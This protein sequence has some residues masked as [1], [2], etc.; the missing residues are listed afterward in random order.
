MNVAQPS[1]RHINCSLQ[2]W[3]DAELQS[4]TNS[5]TSGKPNS[6]DS[7]EQRCA[8]SPTTTSSSMEVPNPSSTSSPLSHKESLLKVAEGGTKSYAMEDLLR[9][10]AASVAEAIRQQNRE[11][12]TPIQ[13]MVL[14]ETTDSGRKKRPNEEFLDELSRTAADALTRAL[15]K[16]AKLAE[17]GLEDELKGLVREALETSLNHI[18]GSRSSLDFD[19]DE[20]QR[21]QQQTKQGPEQMA[22]ESFEEGV[23]KQPQKTP[24]PLKFSPYVPSPTEIMEAFSTNVPE[25]FSQSFSTYYEAL[26]RMFQSQGTTPPCA[27][28][29]PFRPHKFSEQ[30]SPSKADSSKMEVC[31]MDFQ[32]VT[33]NPLPM[34]E[35]LNQTEALALVVNRNRGSS[36]SPAYDHQQE[37]FQPYDSP[38][39]ACIPRKKRTK[40]TDTRLVPPK[41]APQLPLPSMEGGSPFLLS[42]LSRSKIGGTLSHMA[43]PPPLPANIDPALMNDILKTL[44]MAN[45]HNH[46]SC[47]ISSTRGSLS[48]PCSRLPQMDLMGN[49]LP[50][51]PPPQPPP[52]PP[53][54]P[55]HHHHHHHP[56]EFC[57][58]IPNTTSVMESNPIRRSRSIGGKR[59]TNT[60]ST[61]NYGCD[62]RAFL[63]SGSTSDEAAPSLHPGP[64]SGI[65]P[66]TSTLTPIHLRKAK[67]MFFYTR[68]PNSNTLKAYF[69]D[70]KFQK[71][72]TAQL[73]KWFSNFREFYYIQMEKYARVAIT[74]GVRNPNDLTVTTNSELYRTL[75]LHYNRN[76]QIEIPEYFRVVVET[77]IREFFV[78]LKAGKDAEQSW[79][80]PIYKIIARMDQTVPE[81]FKDPTWMAQLA[82]G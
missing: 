10:D 27:F 22:E 21:Q 77:T 57:Y 64:L 12:T 79:K 29:T 25:G 68:Y 7:E 49:L 65:I 9:S 5:G 4:N 48:I 80:K 61:S 23:V 26:C 46:P 54:P 19:T 34:P 18:S 17:K 51:P 1:N 15:S 66:S 53:P 62:G 35:Q 74:E 55:H 43:S 70:V 32:K 47:S 78:A 75:A 36:G 67:L 52:P 8:S 2:K 81:Y 3:L 71:N 13:K 14:E 60:S 16:K 41:L 72:N 38:M 59:V 76:N 40:V 37:N 30:N 24:G 63:S 33:S 31:S 28:P 42:E 6:E 73:V 39:T 11:Q 20:G 69:C 45:G 58:D 50:P 82:D 44:S 56:N